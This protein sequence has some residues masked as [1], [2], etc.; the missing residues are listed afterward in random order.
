MKADGGGLK[1]KRKKI[2]SHFGVTWQVHKQRHHTRVAFGSP[3]Q[4]SSNSWHA[5]AEVSNSWLGP[6]LPP[7][8]RTK[9]RGRRTSVEGASLL[10]AEPGSTPGHK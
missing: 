10:E 7:P 9:S 2:L 3:V 8:T 5:W 6:Q 4:L 1:L